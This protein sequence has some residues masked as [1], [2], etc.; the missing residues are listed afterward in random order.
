MSKLLLLILPLLLYSQ[1]I[2]LFVGKKN[3]DRSYTVKSGDLSSKLDFPSS[4]YFAKWYYIGK[5]R[6]IKYA[7]S[8]ESLLDDVNCIGNDYDFKNKKLKVISSSQD[9][10]KIFKSFS[11]SL[12]KKIHPELSLFGRFKYDDIE[13]FWYNTKQKNLS[14]NKDI[15]IDERTISFFQKN[16]FYFLGIEYIKK[17]DNFVLFVSPSILYGIVDFKDIHEKRDFFVTQYVKS[18]GYSI[19]L[20]LSYRLKKNINIISKYTYKTLKD[21]SVKMDYF[22]NNGYRLNSLNSSYSYKID[23]FSIGIKYEF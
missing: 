12:S 7:F 22:T 3:L 23:S 8:I 4:F 9:K 13:S 10:T 19:D 5:H 15:Y 2:E 11:V 14:N 6:G 17:I 18:F 1:S 21:K 16:Y 20:S